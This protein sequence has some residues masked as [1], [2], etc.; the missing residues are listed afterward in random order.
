ME[1]RPAVQLIKHKKNSAKEQEF[2]KN[3]SP[4]VLYKYYTKFSRLM[5]TKIWKTYQFSEDQKKSI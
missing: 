5:T 1:N 4:S 3:Y 2:R